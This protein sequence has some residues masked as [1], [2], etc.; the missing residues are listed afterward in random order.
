MRAPEM[1]RGPATPTQSRP[2][3]AMDDA[4]GEPGSMTKRSS[5]AGCD[6][7][8]LTEQQADGMSREFWE[9]LPEAKRRAYVDRYCVGGDG[10]L[11]TMG[12]P[13]C[14]RHLRD[15]QEEWREYET[16]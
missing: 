2:A 12:S 1:D 10:L 13:Y 14:E 6:W 5:S 7:E 3:P 4:T 16:D 8:D 9:T 11:R 15:Y